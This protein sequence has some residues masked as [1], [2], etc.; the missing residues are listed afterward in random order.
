[1]RPISIGIRDAKIN[2]S[3][4]LKEVQKGAEVIITDRNKPVGRI[5]PVS[6]EE[7]LP[8]AERIASLEREGLIQPAKKKKARSLPPPLPLPGELARK[9]L[10]EDRG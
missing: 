8:L 3:K 5:V 7:N 1:M 9:M 10:E 6:T 4:L 2:L